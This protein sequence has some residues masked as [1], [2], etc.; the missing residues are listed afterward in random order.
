MGVERKSL[1]ISDDEKR[2]TAYHESGHVLVSK[3]LPGMD[4]IHKVTIIP[5]GMALG[6]T[7]ALP[8]DERR[9]YSKKYCLNQLAFM[10]GGRAAEKLV[11]G[12]L[13]TGAGNDIEKATK[14]ARKMICQWGMSE[15][16]GP[17]TY[18]EKQEEIFLGREI[19]MHR[20]YSEQTAREI[21]E[22]VK[23][24]VEAAESLAESIIK[25]DIKKL[26]KLAETLLEKEILAGDEIDKIL[27]IKKNKRKGKNTEDDKSRQKE[28]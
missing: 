16:L 28:N 4:P 15:R 6:L 18:G 7:Q 3:S 1:L 21:D 2:L 11:L 19:G 26:K 25:K 23:K 14:L 8:I 22:E 20:D 9:T 27:Q 13:S 10:L 12:D 17:L 5:R 24:L